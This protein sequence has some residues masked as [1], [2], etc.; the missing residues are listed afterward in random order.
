MI[1]LSTKKTLITEVDNL[2]TPNDIAS[3][4]KLPKIY[5]ESMLLT[6]LNSC[7]SEF[8]RC[9]GILLREYLCLSTFKHRYNTRTDCITYL[10]YKNIK[11]LKYINGFFLNN[12]KYPLNRGYAVLEDKILWDIHIYYDYVEICYISGGLGIDP[13]IKMKLMQRIA[14]IY[15][16]KTNYDNRYEPYYYKPN[17]I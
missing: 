13:E 5:D 2:I 17:I 12:K 16:N 11:E 14:Y 3:F 10:P 15:N 6:I 1:L 4:L 7:I 9:S 8:E